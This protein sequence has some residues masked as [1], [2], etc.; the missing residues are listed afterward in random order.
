MIES[1]RLLLRRCRPSDVDAVLAYRSRAD[2]AAYLSAGVWSR[3]HTERELM[4]Y[5]NAS[6]REPGDELVLLAETRETSRIAGEVGLLWRATSPSVAEVGYVFNPDFGG[7]GLATEAV[8]ATVHWAL[9]ERNF[10][11]VIA[12][13]DT[14]NAAS[15]ALCERIGMS[16]I[17]TTVSTDGRN[18]A[19]CTYA[20]GSGSAPLSDLA[21]LLRVDQS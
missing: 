17:A 2:V 21:V 10:S 9:V 18:V 3:E 15:R 16:V 8:S 1:A 5:A 14:D 12:V 11:F 7:Q 4:T 19:E 20:V 6:F 13:T